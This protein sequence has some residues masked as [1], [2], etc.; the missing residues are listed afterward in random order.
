[1][2][3]NLNIELIN[4]SK[5]NTNFFCGVC[6]YPLILQEDFSKNEKFNCCYEC[7]L[8]FIQSREKEFEEGYK[9]NKEKLDEYLKLRKHIN[10]KIINITGE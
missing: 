10:E 9:I 1:M 7:Y 6:N 3:I 2:Y 5:N 8:T 4:K